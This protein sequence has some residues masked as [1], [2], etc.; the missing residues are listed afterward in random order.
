M[1]RISLELEDD[2]FWLLVDQADRLNYSSLEAF[3]VN[4]L[5]ES[6]D[7]LD[8]A[9]LLLKSNLGTQVPIPLK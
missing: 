1:K 2:R 7:R 3:L 6:M 4:T 8:D 5:Y 9:E